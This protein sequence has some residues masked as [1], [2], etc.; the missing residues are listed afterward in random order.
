MAVALRPRIIWSSPLLARR[1]PAGRGVRSRTRLVSCVRCFFTP[2]LK[3][4]TY[5]ELN[6]WLT[7]KIIA[8]AKRH[9]HPER[10]RTYDLGDV[11]RGAAA[12]CCLS[13]P[14]DGFHALPASV[15]TTCLVRSTNNKYSVNAAAIGRPVEIFAYADRVVIPSGGPRPLQ[16]TRAAMGA[17]RRSTIP[18]IMSRSS[19]V[20]RAPCA[21]ARHSRTGCCQLPWSVS[22]ASSPG[23]MMAIARWSKFWR[24]FSL[25]ACRPSRLPVLK[26]WPRRP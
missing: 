13:R 15:S 6:A 24:P 3:F 11:R 8:Y 5:D 4:K 18:G 1:R 9:P 12:A 25:T 16:N 19:P 26:P 2:R 14:F 21:M 23:P 17:A 20:S 7:D 10:P 22:D